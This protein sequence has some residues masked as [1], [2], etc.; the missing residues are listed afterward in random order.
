MAAA[1]ATLLKVWTEKTHLQMQQHARTLGDGMERWSD[2]TVGSGTPIVSAIA[3]GTASLRRGPR[4]NQE[5]G[6]YDLPLV[7]HVQRVFMTNQ[8]IWDFGWRDG[9]AMSAQT[10]LEG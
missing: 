7:R 10:T 1:R 3:P 2:H 4:N 8:G 6:A 9:P 5:A